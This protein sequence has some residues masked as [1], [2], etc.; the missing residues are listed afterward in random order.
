VAGQGELALARG[1]AEEALALE[2]ELGN[3]H[4]IAA[5]FNA[6]AQIHRLEGDLGSAE[7]LYEK[8]VAL[9]REDGE[10][11]IIAIGLL[12]IAMV[13][14]GRGLA[15]RAAALLLEVAAIGEEIGSKL[16]GQSVL[17]VSAGLAALRGEWERAA[18]FFG[19]AEAQAGQTGLRRDPADEAFLA[20]WM[21]K[22]HMALRDAFDAP[23]V[24]GSLLSYEE[25]IAEASGWLETLA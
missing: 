6:L 13:S 21:E 16:V 19:A 17:D 5:A 12:N 2:Q 20:Q 14:I 25:A 15:D 8:V 9:A 22:A 1:H 18:R 7:P 11:E 10:R 3:K 23:S 24:A 4:Q